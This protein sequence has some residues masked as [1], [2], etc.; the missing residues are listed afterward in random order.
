MSGLGDPG[1]DEHLLRRMK[2]QRDR[3]LRRRWIGLGLVAVLIGYVVVFGDTGWLA[4]R[5][6]QKDVDEREA[7]LTALEDATAAD[8]KALR[9][10]EE[11]GGHALERIA[12]ER[13]RMQRPGEEVYH[14]VG[15]DESEES[16]DAP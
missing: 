12:R 8:E 1:R 14:L 11:P 4:V 15:E 13:Y 9:E 16:R 3:R 7:L 5:D 10:L 6:A 2:A